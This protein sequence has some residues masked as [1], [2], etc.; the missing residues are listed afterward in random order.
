MPRAR[1]K[2]KTS[3]DPHP[4]RCAFLHGK[5]NQGKL[6]LLKQM[7]QENVRLINQDIGF[8]EG[9][10][11]IALQLIKNDKKD[12][13]VRAL[14]KTLRKDGLN[15]AFCQ[16]AFDSAFAKL[17]N[18]LNA[19][20]INMY[21]EMPGIFT[22]SKV[23]FAM[24]VMHCSKDDMR[25]TMCDI[26]SHTKHNSEYYLEIAEELDAMSVSAFSDAMLTFNDLYVQECIQFKVPIVKH[27]QV[28]L[29]T[30]LMKLSRAAHTQTTHV[31]RITDPFCKAHRFDIPINASRYALRKLKEEK[32]ASSVSFRTTKRGLIRVQ[33]AYKCTISQPATNRLCG[34]DIGMTD[35]FFLSDG[36]SI[37]SM[38]DVIAFYKQ[39]V[40]P[41]FAELSHLREK[42]AHI[43]HYVRTHQLKADVRKNLLAKVDRL[44]HMIKTANAP[45]RKKRHYYALLNQKVSQCVKQYVSHT[46]SNVL[47]VLERLD[48][49]AFRKS[50]KVNGS[51]SV[52]ARGLLQ[53]KLMSELNIAGRDFIE[54][55]PDFTSQ[56]CP[57]CGH[58]SEA[59]RHGKDFTCTCCGHHDDADHN[60]AVNIKQRAEDTEILDICSNVKGHSKIQKAML[61]TY[62]KRNQTWA[63][64]HQQEAC[65]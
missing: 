61:I 40:E 4:V 48:I 57:V 47:T 1:K 21:Q 59:N 63:A 35:C 2:K 65:A 3:F 46:P 52:F 45:Y 54:V 36:R 16:N 22:Q 43:L 49:K 44:E 32:A 26:A 18:R 12:P 30:R 9:R 6:K 38:K 60:A 37:G 20:R 42:K 19:I 39:T 64:A 5:P 58:V 17:S 62:A 28:M 7:E 53:K 31:I 15:S 25:Q 8:L 50:H 29:D 27:E 34:V 14:E 51:L 55:E 24:C 13:Y 33:I 11:D 41:A 56:L 23:L 10:E